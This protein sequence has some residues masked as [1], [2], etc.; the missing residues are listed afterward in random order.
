MIS[1]DDCTTDEALYSNYTKVRCADKNV[2]WIVLIFLMGFILLTNLLLFN[3]LI[4]IFSKAFEK[5]EGIPLLGPFEC[6]NYFLCVGLAL[7]HY[8]H[9][10]NNLVNDLHSNATCHPLTFELVHFLRK[11]K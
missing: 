8:L 6:T 9:V 1:E 5:I 10:I 2:N 3:L 7:P 11:M 4:A